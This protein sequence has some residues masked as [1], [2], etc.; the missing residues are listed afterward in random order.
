MIGS[1]PFSWLFP[2]MAAVVHHGGAGTTSMG[3]WAGI[4]SIVTPF[5]GDQPFWGRRVY[6]LG[7]GP[8]PIPRRRL[9]VDG[10]AESIRCAVSDTAMRERAA[11]LGECIRAENGIARAVAIIEQN[12]GHK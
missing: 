11:R 9:T 7:V 6:E 5:M 4:P 8:Q 2:R 10:L 1:T 12:I 3:L